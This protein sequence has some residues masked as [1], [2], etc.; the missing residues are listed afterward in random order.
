M[1]CKRAIPAVF[2]FV[3]VLFCGCS[4]A[5]GQELVNGTLGRKVQGIVAAKKKTLKGAV[6][7]I[8]V[9]S[10][11]DKETVYK[12]DAG[13]AF[14]VASNMKLATTAAALAKMG[15]D[16]ELS[17]ALCRRG[18]IDSGVLKGDLVAIGMGDPNISGRFYGG[19]AETVLD[20]WAQAVKAVGID[21]VDGSVIADGTAYG[22]E[23]IPPGWPQNQLEKWYCAPVSALSINDNCFDVTVGPGSAPGKAAFVALRPR[24][25]AVSLS[26]QCGTTSSR[27]KHLISVLRKPATNDVIVKGAYLKGAQA[28][29]FNV[30]VHN[31][32]LVFG[33]ALVEALKRVG[34]KVNAGVEVAKKPVE[35]KGLVQIARHSTPLSTAVAVTNKRS[36][37]L[38]AELLLREL[39]RISGDGS[40][41][42]GIKALKGFMKS[43]GVP[44]SQVSPDDGCGLSG[45]SKLSASAIVGLLVYMSAHKDFGVFRESLAISGFDGTLENRLDSAAHKGKVHAKTGYIRGVSALSGY[46]KNK[47][48]RLFAFSILVNKGF[49]LSNTTM[50]SVQDEIV[51]AILDS[52]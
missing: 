18:S 40:R 45:D 33:S 25:G 29:V 35:T 9:Q 17:A 20:S 4:E 28:R 15:K 38:H 21:V 13:T 5:G 6:I 27:S 22:G 47:S 14:S 19:N 41:E 10:L 49:R 23:T 24:A 3:A 7:S 36:Q 51:R 39:G 46:A 12:L 30:T 43:I 50:K 26:N 1:G 32:A 34:V 11:D 16:H 42:G 48:G 37:N 2:L 52:K 44:S 31:P 8:H